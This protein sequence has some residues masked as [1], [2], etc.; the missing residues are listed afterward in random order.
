MGYSVEEISSSD[1]FTVHSV[2]QCCC[3]WKCCNVDIVKN[4]KIPCPTCE[5]KK[6][7]EKK[8]HEMSKRIISDEPVL[9]DAVDIKVDCQ[10]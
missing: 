1:S 8:S 7:K 10:R 3:S 9:N 6:E 2:V 4:E 5:P